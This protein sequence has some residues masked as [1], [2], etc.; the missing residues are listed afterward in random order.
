[1][2]RHATRADE[3]DRLL[4]GERLIDLY[5]VV[6]QALRAG[7]ESYSIKQLEQFYEFR[8]DV[9][10]GDASQHLQAIELALESVAPDTIPPEARDAVRG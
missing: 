10:L 2:G 1:M 4:R 8:R 7:V 3:L 9:P 5:A 6:R